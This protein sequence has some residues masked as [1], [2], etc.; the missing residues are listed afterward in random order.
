[1]SFRVFFLI[2]LF[3][4]I[5][6]SV[7]FLNPYQ[8]EAANITVSG[9]VY[10]DEGTTVMT[11]Q[12]TIRA[13]VNGAGTYST[14]A[15]SDGTYSIGSV[16]IT[17]AGDVVTVY[18]DNA[19]ENANTITI[20]N[21][22]SSNIVNFDLYQNRIIVR[23]ENSGPIDWADVDAYCSASCTG[24]DT[25]MMFQKFGANFIAAAGSEFFVPSGET[26]DIGT[27]T[28][29][30][31]DLDVNGTF[32]DSGAQLQSGAATVTWDWTGGI[33]TLTGDI[34]IWGSD[35]TLTSYGNA[36]N[37][38]KIGHTSSDGYLNN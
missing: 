32:L 29:Q 36:I 20:T 3:I 37:N 38:I 24:T 22:N 31:R 25:D 1:M 18:I 12:R 8:S 30:F 17:S 2:S 15:A 9:T 26:Y 13:R 16:A 34:R 14:T 5:T 11:T 19:T 23:H 33:V 35:M 28:H 10:T 21:D 6:I 27:G 7:V 4:F